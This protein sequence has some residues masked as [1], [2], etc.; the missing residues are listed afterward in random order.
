MSTYLLL[1][2]TSR[3]LVAL[4]C[5]VHKTECKVRSNGVLE[6]TMLRWHM[7]DHKTETIDIR[8]PTEA[9]TPVRGLLMLAWRGKPTAPL[10]AAEMFASGGYA[11]M[12][13]RRTEPRHK[14]TSDGGPD[15]S[16]PAS[17]G[18]VCRASPR[19]GIACMDS[20]RYLKE[21]AVAGTVF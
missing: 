5:N 7:S 17:G 20:V 11:R 10:T 6:M 15:Q 12:R 3:Q 14:L 4:E 18:V 2:D 13:M 16:P 19:N 9:C 8:E 1:S 21:S